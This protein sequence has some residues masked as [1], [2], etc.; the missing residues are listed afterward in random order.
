M[1]SGVLGKVGG[2]GQPQAGLM[3]L[4]RHWNIFEI[5]FSVLGIGKCDE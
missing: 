2:A 5:F 1:G 3:V 4:S